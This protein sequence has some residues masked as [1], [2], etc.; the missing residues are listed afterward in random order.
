MIIK[1]WVNRGEIHWTHDND[2]IVPLAITQR[3]IGVTLRLD[4][5]GGPTG[6][7]D[8]YGGQCAMTMWETARFH[9]GEGL[10]CRFQ[11]SLG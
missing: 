8:G 6:A 3:L 5:G 2:P 7:S 10:Q 4:N 9:D 11:R 1:D